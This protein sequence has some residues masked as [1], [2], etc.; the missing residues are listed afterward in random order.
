VNE[1]QAELE[2]AHDNSVWCQAVVDEAMEKATVTAAAASATHTVFKVKHQACKDALSN[3]SITASMSHQL[4][5]EM[6]ISASVARD[7]LDEHSRAMEVVHAAKA[8][9]DKAVEEYRQLV[10]RE[11]L[12]VDEVARPL[13]EGAL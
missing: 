11:A 4:N 1:L 7:A 3:P 8:E 9:S 10:L 12:M 5:A 6:G 13:L 2:T